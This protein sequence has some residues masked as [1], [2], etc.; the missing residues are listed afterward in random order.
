MTRTLGVYSIA[1]FEAKYGFYIVVERLNE[2]KYMKSVRDNDDCHLPKVNSLEML[3]LPQSRT[4]G[5]LISFSGGKWAGF[6]TF[7]MYSG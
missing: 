2:L 7:A 3:S 6:R 1:D 5:D 4:N